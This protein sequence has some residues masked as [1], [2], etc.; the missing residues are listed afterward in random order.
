MSGLADLNG[1]HWSGTAELWLDPLGDSAQRS[2]CTVA[3]EENTVRYT[4]VYDGR[5]QQGKITLDDS[6]AVFIDT[7]H[8]PEPMACTRVPE[9]RGLFQVQG[10]Y[11]PDANWGW[12][13]TLCQRQP[14]GELILQM[15][16]I[17]PWGEET[18]AVRMIANRA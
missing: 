11:G 14:S 2:E 13:L 16:N 6:G 8:Q 3:V 18:R 12:R 1:S 4:W 7:W 17:A 5:P 9:A 15:T 10:A